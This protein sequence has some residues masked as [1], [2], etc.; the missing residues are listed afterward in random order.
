MDEK[1][2]FYSLGKEIY[3][4]DAVYAN[5]AKQ[6]GVP[7][8]L[9]WILYALND[10]KKHTQIEICRT[11]DLPK[12]TVNTII[13]DLENNSYIA[14]LPIKGKKREMTIVLTDE[15]KKYANEILTELYKIEAE[16]YSLLTDKDFEI[17][18]TLRK[19][20]TFITKNIK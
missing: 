14:L 11:W 15:G 7:P 4:L 20:T 5:F 19:I 6:S 13:K 10:G 9:M 8:T 12:S 1:A 16:L 3:N 2:F 18:S 17:L